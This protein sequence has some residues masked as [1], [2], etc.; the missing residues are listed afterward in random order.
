M[1][2]SP[3]PPK[4]TSPKESASYQSMLEEVESIV[5]HVS[6]GPLDLDDV[7]SK[8]E[9]GYKLI[10]TMRSRLDATK[11]KVETLRSEFEQDLASGTTE[12]APDRPQNNNDDDD[13]PF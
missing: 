13:T 11:A 12:D 2:K 1:A 3:T 5:R 10:R 7:V 8:V 4:T 9:Q 6:S